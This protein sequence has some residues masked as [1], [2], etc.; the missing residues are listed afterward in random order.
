M[1]VR[2]INRPWS[3]KLSPSPNGAALAKR[4]VE[5]ERVREKEGIRLGNLFVMCGDGVTER[6]GGR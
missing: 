5:E 1:R 3:R 2:D 6:E 4:G